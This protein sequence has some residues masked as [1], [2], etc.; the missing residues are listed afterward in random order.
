MH[1]AGNAIERALDV[2]ARAREHEAAR[3]PEPPGLGFRGSARMRCALDAQ[4]A[5]SR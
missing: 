5:Y 4:A 2:G 3:V 1:C